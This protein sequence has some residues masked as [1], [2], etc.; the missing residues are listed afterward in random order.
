MLNA[1]HTDVGVLAALCD[2]DPECAGFNSAGALKANVSGR[3]AAPGVT[4]FVKAGGPAVYASAAPVG[5]G[6]GVHGKPILPPPR[7]PA[8]PRRGAGAGSRRG[9]PSRVAPRA[10]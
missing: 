7:A 1:W 5:R 9:G 3:V 8:T 2:R 4:L 6:A 10:A